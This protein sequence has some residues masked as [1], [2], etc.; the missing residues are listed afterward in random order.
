MQNKM[1][2]VI[3]TFILELNQEDV[4]ALAHHEPQVCAAGDRW[5]SDAQKERLEEPL[6]PTLK[7]QVAKVFPRKRILKNDRTW[8]IL[9]DKTKVQCSQK[10]HCTGL[11][12]I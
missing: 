5:L 8:S 9:Q 3:E 10:I 2:V 6:Q 11:Q 4:T 1:P 7:E 12:G